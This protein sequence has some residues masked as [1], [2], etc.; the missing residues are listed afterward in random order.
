VIAAQ[1]FAYVLPTIFTQLIDQFPVDSSTG[2]LSSN[3]TT[4]YTSSTQAYH[5]L[6]FA[7]VNGTEYAYITDQGNAVVYQ[8]T[9][10]NIDGAFNTCSALL[11][12]PGWSPYAIAFATVNNVQYAYVSDVSNGNI[13][14]CSLNPDGSFS[15]CPVAT[16]ATFP[17]PYGIAFATINNT[18]YAYI[19]DAGVGGPGNYGNVYQ[20]P[21]N[22]DGTL[23]SC[24]IAT[25]PIITPQWIPYAT[26]FT[27]VA[28]IQYAYVADNGTT[29][30]SG[31]VYLCRLDPTDGLFT[32]CNPTPSSSAPSW[33]PYS[34][35][36]ATLEGTQYAYISSVQ[37]PVGGGL[38]RCILANSGVGA[39][40]NCQLTPTS[41]PSSWQPIG[42][43]FR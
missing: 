11:A 30:S 10:N 1:I 32:Q 27:S 4:A 33:N 17:A 23:A 15:N 36:F 13:Y 18:Q 25:S 21:V 28:G 42:V 24:T 26:A 41:P 14:Q 6:T 35:A 38:Y 39:L 29:P 20:C 22:N 7:T 19:S 43:T 9:I 2:L 16:P 3:P 8:C 31:N 40:S 34:I 37:G 12:P 5:Q